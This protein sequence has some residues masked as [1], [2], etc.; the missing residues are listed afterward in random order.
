[1]TVALARAEG[2]VQAAAMRSE[3]TR[4]VRGLLTALSERRCR[5]DR[6]RRLLRCVQLREV[7][8]AIDRGHVAA[9]E[10]PGEAAPEGGVEVLVEFAERDPHWCREVGEFLV[11]LGIRE[12]GAIQITVQPQKRSQGARLLLE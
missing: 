6:A 9:P 2:V 1:M 12:N 3:H 5:Q 7:P 11:P 10:E 4:S 8:G